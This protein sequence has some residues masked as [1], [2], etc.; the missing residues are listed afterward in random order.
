MSSEPVSGHS[1]PEYEDAHGDRPLT[2]VMLALSTFRRSEEAA[3]I[4]I[5]KAGQ[6][7]TLVIAYVADVNLARYFVGTDVGLYPE[8]EETC[9]RELLQKHREAGERRLGELAERAE[10]KG[11]TVRTRVEIGRFARVCL[12]M[13]AR[14]RPDL[15]VTT[16]SSRPGWVRRFFGSPVDELVRKAGCPVIEV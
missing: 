9:E 10:R 14:E 12:E 5:E 6:A 4:A 13:I 3:G 15:V 1:P 7:G 8:L 2:T 11:I 16:R